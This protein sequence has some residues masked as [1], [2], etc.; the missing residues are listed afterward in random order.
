MHKSKTRK[1][2]KILEVFGRILEYVIFFS[3]RGHKLIFYAKF[4]K[5]EGLMITVMKRFCNRVL[6]SCLFAN[7][8]L[9]PV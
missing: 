5:V 3:Q 9:K 2:I 6:K 8:T 7:I 1:G 4:T